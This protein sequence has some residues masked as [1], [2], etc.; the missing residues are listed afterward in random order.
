MNSRNKRIC[1]KIKEKN[2]D[3]GEARG[4]TKM[5]TKVVV[6]VDPPRNKIIIPE[7]QH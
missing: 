4:Q 2:F 1:L 5:Q 3:Y 7:Y 6:V